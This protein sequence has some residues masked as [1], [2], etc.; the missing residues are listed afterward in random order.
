MKSIDEARLEEDLVYRFEY[1]CEFIGFGPEDQR[2]IQSCAPYLGP[3]I[4]ALVE[5]TYTKLL[6]YDATARHF[7]ARQHGYTGPLPTTAVELTQSH[8]QV[9][10]RKEHLSKYFLQLLGRNYDAKM[11]QYLDMVGKIHTPHAGNAA[12]QIPLVQM[13]ALLGQMADVLTEC[14]TQLGLDTA[15]MIATLRAFQKLFWIQNDFVSRHYM[16]GG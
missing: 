9:Q 4:G 13:N 14:I 11:V 3:Q 16:H 8:P 5:A 1:L 7:V 2:A 10:F 6:S 15:T 12:I